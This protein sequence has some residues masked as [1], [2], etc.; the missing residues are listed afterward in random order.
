M[1]PF[2][3]E[4][5]RIY[6]SGKQRSSVEEQIIFWQNEEFLELEK[7]V[8]FWKGEKASFA[9]DEKRVENNVLN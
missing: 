7:K 2:F 6:S 4:A 9:K 3:D 8:V 5:G 1:F